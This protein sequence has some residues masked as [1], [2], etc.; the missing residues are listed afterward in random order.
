MTRRTSLFQRTAL[1][2]AVGLFIFQIA[3][4]AAMFANLVLPLAQRSADDLADL[5]IL[6]AQIW[7][8]LPPEKRPAFEQELQ[9][10]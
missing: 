5:L 8:E 6:S 2:V 1:T 4:G 7:V 10:K 3:S 9:D